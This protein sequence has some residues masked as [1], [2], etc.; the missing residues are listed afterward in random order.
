MKNKKLYYLT[1]FIVLFL[2]IFSFVR[3]KNKT[4]ELSKD[5]FALGTVNKITIYGVNKSDG[6][7]ILDKCGEIILDIENKMSNK[8]S[9]SEVN[10]INAASGNSFVKVS[11]NTYSVIDTSL[12]YSKLSDGYFD[13]TIGP[14]STLW[15]IGTDEARVPAKSEIDNLLPLV[16]YKNVLL[17]DKEKSVK[18]KI[19]D[20][21]LDLGGI[22]KGYAA[23]EL[24]KYLKSQGVESGIVNL[25]GNIYV[26]GSNKSGNEYNIG[27]QDPNME[28]GNA[29]GS[30]KVKDMSVV[31][32]GI[33]ERFLEKD[34][35][36]YHHILSPFDGYPIDNELSGVTIIS[37]NSTICD[38][39]STSTFGLGVDNG[40]ALIN[41]LDNVDAIFVTKDKKI[42]LS[43]GAKDIFELTNKEYKIVNS[44]K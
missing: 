9:S 17:N 30:V 8:I 18:L 13:P 44:H 21:K 33:Y 43:N 37:D 19:K 39:L 38:A 12:K 4:Y 32:S 35:K 20:M 25:G 1:S 22:A 15:N 16:S 41:K 28:N 42:Y 29:I 6:Q 27:I 7:K 40:L 34:G 5:Y 10:K 14:I 11:D 23:D 3:F 2:I 36:Y 24:V 26:I 31:T